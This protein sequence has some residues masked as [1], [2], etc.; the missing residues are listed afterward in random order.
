VAAWDK[1]VPTGA[2]GFGFVDVA[3]GVVTLTKTVVVRNLDDQT[4]TYTVTPTF[5]FAD[6]VANGAVTVSAPS[7]V[8]VQPGL[9][10]ETTFDVTLTIQGALLRGNYM[11]S[12]S[13]GANPSVLT[14]MSTT[15][16]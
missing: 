4:H 7:Q 5:R 14:S 1:D 8:V 11:N 13:N 10:K 12:G 6:D 15:G 16:T 3:D 2:L 9:G